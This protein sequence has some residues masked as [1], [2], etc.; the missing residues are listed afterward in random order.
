ME[1]GKGERNMDTTVM[2]YEATVSKNEYSKTAICVIAD[3]IHAKRPKVVFLMETFVDKNKMGAVCVQVGYDNLFVVDAI[4][5]KGGLIWR[6]F[7][8]ILWTLGLLVLQTITSTQS[9]S[10]MWVDPIGASRDTMV[11]QRNIGEWMLWRML[12]SLAAQS[13]LP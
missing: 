4:G 13:T 5:H 7:G 10:L 6:S 12:R 8:Q 2:D 11:S 3:H 1:E 9:C